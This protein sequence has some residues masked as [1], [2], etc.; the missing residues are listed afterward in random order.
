MA[1]TVETTCRR[2]DRVGQC[3]GLLQKAHEAPAQISIRL[4]RA[5]LEG[6]RSTR[7]VAVKVD[8]APVTGYAR[9][10]GA[11]GKGAGGA[12]HGVPP[13][14]ETRRRHR[15]QCKASPREF[16]NS[17]SSRSKATPANSKCA[18]PSSSISYSARGGRMIAFTSSS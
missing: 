13:S 11:R 17:M 5:C 6:L 8:D 2:C 14:G 15:L 12:A 10:G 9:V 18:G 3:G 7:G 16:R 4:G 1:S